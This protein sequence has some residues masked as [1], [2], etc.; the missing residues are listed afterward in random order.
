MSN[1]YISDTIKEQDNMLLSNIDKKY[2]PF[3]KRL[4]SQYSSDHP[5]YLIAMKYKDDVHKL[6][7]EIQEALAFRR[8]H[9]LYLLNEFRS[10]K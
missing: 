2:R 1:N 7:E 10:I 3:A 9:V 8:A 5:L 6:K 4:L